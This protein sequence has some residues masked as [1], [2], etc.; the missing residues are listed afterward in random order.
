M[1]RLCQKWNKPPAHQILRVV[2]RH[3]SSGG[4]RACGQI[5]R[6][7]APGLFIQTNAMNMMKQRLLAVCL[8]AAVLILVAC[9]ADERN[10]PK[11]DT[12]VAQS[13]QTTNT[14]KPFSREDFDLAV[15]S[16]ET[17][18]DYVKLTHAEHFELVESREGG[19]EIFM[20]ERAKAP[21]YINLVAEA[22][23]KWLKNGSLV[24]PGN[25]F[26]TLPDEL[27]KSPASLWRLKYVRLPDTPRGVV[28]GDTAE[29]VLSS[30]LR[31]GPARGFADQVLYEIKTQTPMEDYV[32][33]TSFRG[34][35]SR[36][37]DLEQG[38]S[39]LINYSQTPDDGNGRSFITYGI[40]KN[41]K[42][43][44]IELGQSWPH[45]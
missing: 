28:I 22:P 10:T 2:Y 7:H 33:T 45:D 26:S 40:D 42:V 24:L 23:K 17:V 9:N 3:D 44:Y 19:V 20:R 29:K 8:G 16:L 14:A 15:K 4:Q 37:K 13:A 25:T 39:F 38:I 18:E 1:L 6:Q 36:G 41:N 30:Y 21:V 43:K 5:V 31:T 11:T 32:F 35:I 27:L 12:P 34:D